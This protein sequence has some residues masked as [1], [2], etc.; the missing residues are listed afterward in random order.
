MRTSRFRGAIGERSGACT[1]LAAEGKRR[2]HYSCFCAFG[3]GT[4]Q[5]FVLWNKDEVLESREGA[6]RRRD[7]S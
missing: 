4:N 2:G 5:V 7:Q 6:L 1:C 3:F